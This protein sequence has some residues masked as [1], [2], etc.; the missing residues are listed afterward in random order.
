MR[1]SAIVDAAEC[2]CGCG[3]MRL[4]KTGVLTKNKNEVVARNISADT[5]V[6]ILF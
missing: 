3:W 1:L 4:W 2:E 6:L 5:D